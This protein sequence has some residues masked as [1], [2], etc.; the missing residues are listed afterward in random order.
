[1]LKKILRAFVTVVCVTALII[2]WLFTDFLGKPRYIRVSTLDSHHIFGETRFH[3][4]DKIESMMI[5]SEDNLK[6]VKYCPDLKELW[7]IRKLENFEFLNNPKLKT[8]YALKGC[9]GFSGL[10]DIQSLENLRVYELHSENLSC[11]TKLNNLKYLEFVTYEELDCSGI[12]NLQN[13]EYLYIGA[14]KINC[15]QLSNLNKVKEIRLNCT[16]NVPNIVNISD[17]LNLKSLEKIE[18]ADYD[19]GKELTESFEKNGVEIIIE[20]I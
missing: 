2:L 6:Y 17:L 4:T 1:M 10:E 8:I 16:G 5:E 14:A 12:E 15:S 7:S 18:L 11:I 13:L 9:C 20:Y 19:L 3:N